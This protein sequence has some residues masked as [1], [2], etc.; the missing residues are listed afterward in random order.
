[1]L[2]STS[3]VSSHKYEVAGL[4][5]VALYFGVLAGLYIKRVPMPTRDGIVRY[6]HGRRY[7]LPYLWLVVYGL[8]ATLFLLAR[9]F[10]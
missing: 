8:L 10:S 3:L 2:E 1:M 6:E 7:V 9:L 4:F 5:A